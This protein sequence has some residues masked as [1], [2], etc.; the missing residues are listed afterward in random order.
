MQ[1]YAPYTLFPT[2]VQPLE[3]YTLNPHKL[4]VSKGVNT[5][6]DYEHPRC[7]STTIEV[8]DSEGEYP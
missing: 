4:W 5:Y 6:P 1:T 3:V 7:E 8:R 2:R